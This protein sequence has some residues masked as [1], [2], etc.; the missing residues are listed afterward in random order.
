MKKVTIGLKF[1]DDVI[2]LRHRSEHSHCSGFGT[3]A[4]H[5]VDIGIAKVNFDV[6]LALDSCVFEKFVV[7]RGKVWR[8]FGLG[9]C[10]GCFIR[11]CWFG[12]CFVESYFIFEK[13]EFDY[14]HDAPGCCAAHH[15]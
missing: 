13:F 1:V 4:Q 5:A 6:V 12:S 11:S 9:C 8:D 14:Y 7:L 2:K 3:E 10:C 15:A